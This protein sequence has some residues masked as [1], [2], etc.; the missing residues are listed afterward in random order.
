MIARV[1]I[2]NQLSS[3]TREGGR[4]RQRQQHGGQRGDDAEQRDDADMQAG[5]GDL[6]RQ[7]RQKPIT[8]QAMT[9][10]WRDQQHDV[11]CTAPNST[12]SSRGTIGVRPVR[13]R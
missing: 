10:A 12:T 5:A 4:R 2:V 8:C 3:D 13:M 1:A 11:D 7:A 6:A 9:P